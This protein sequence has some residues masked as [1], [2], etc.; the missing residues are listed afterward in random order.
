[1]SPPLKIQSGVIGLGNSAIDYLAVVPRFPEQ[2]EKMRVLEFTKQ[3]GRP[4][5]TALVT[6]ARFGI[7]TGYVGKVGGD[8]F[9]RFTLRRR[10]NRG[11]RCFPRSFHLW[12]FKGWNLRKITEF[13][14][15]VA[16]LKCTKLGGRAGIPRLLQVL[17][18]LQKH[19]NVFAY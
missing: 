19:N 3:G 17:N 7:P 1:M 12:T 10:Y 11:R 14:N 2:N 6:L 16:G 15:I 8:D 5:A 18:F 13:S 9:G 4:V